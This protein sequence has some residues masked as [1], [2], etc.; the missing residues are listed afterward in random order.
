M[1]PIPGTLIWGV[2]KGFILVAFFL[3]II[4]SLVVVR[5]VQLMTETLEV[6]FEA[7]LKTISYLHL[8]FAILVFLAALIVL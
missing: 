6:G 3:Y 5:Q 2:A 4:F 8:A 7:Q 1:I